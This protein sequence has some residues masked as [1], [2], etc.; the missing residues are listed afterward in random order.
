MRSY[1]EL[2]EI[3]DN[4]HT[5]VGRG[6]QQEQLS[7]ARIA[8]QLEIPGTLSPLTLDALS[9]LSGKFYLLV[10]GEMWCPDCQINVTALNKMCE[11]QPQIQMSVISKG[12]AEDEI[13]KDLGLEEILIP[14]VAILDSDYQVVGRFIEGPAPVAVAEPSD[15]VKNNYA[16]GKYLNT[17]VCEI[18]EQIK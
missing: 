15:A 2:F 3:G 11:F 14:V 1:K 17:T 6:T 12:R 7:V 10:A 8:A 4:F 16:E 5:Y 9:N 13:M 18:L